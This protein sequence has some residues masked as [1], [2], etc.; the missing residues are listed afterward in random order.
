MNFKQNF[1]TTQNM[2]NEICCGYFSVWRQV[3]MLKESTK[4]SDD[5][6]ELNSNTVCLGVKCIQEALLFSTITAINSWFIDQYKQTA[7]LH[8]V[9]SKLK[10]DTFSSY[11]ENWYS[12]PPKTI[13]LNTI[14]TSSW[15]EPF[16]E[17]KKVEFK[18]KRKDVLYKYECFISSDVYK[19][20]RDLR[21]KYVAHKDFKNGQLYNVEHHSHQISDSETILNTIEEFIFTLNQLM[22]KSA[23][24]DDSKSFESVSR[25]FWSTF[26][27]T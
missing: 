8:H 2:L 26:T 19:R 9:I 24:L 21:R 14:D 16:I 6:K 13:K 17:E 7:S 23:Y 12:K 10:D 11:L 22:N 1:P 18:N 27:S 5:I 20:V 15:Y 4:N 3:L 25:E